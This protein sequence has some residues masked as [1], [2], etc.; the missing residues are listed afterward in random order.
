MDGIAQSVQ[1][2]ATGWTVRDLIPVEARFSVPVQT[3]SEAH[4]ASY[5]MGAWSFPGVKRPGLGGD[6]PP[7]LGPRLNKEY[8]YNSTSPLGLRGLFHGELYLYF[9]F[10][11]VVDGRIGGLQIPHKTGRKWKLVLL[12]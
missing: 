1:R 5:T 9:N 2:L 3:G 10:T 8:S 4:P 6:H 7:H 11:A 12:R